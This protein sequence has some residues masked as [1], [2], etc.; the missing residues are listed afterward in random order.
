MH[1]NFK[2]RLCCNSVLLFSFIDSIKIFFIIYLIKFVD[3]DRSL[4]VKIDVNKFNDDFEIKNITIIPLGNN[5]DAF[6]SDDKGGLCGRWVKKV[7]FMAN[8]NCSHYVKETKNCSAK[9]KELVEYW[10]HVHDLF[11][12]IHFYCKVYVKI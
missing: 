11:T 1:Q 6:L 7:N 9:T 8:F 3:Y 2:H 10:R 12:Y 4:L 5:K